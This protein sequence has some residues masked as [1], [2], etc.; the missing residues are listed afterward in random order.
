MPLPAF[1]HS[2]SKVRRRRSHDALKTIMVSKCAKCQAPS[3]PHRVCEACGYYAGRQVK[4][5]MAEVA[6][7]LEKKAKKA[8]AKKSKVSE[9]EPVAESK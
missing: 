2:K 9:A 4:G 8:T 6:K 7:T 3:L 1:R 5:G